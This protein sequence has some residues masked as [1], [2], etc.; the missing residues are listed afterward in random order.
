MHSCGTKFSTVVEVALRLYEFIF[1]RPR[2]IFS[3]N[4]LVRTYPCVV[5]DSTAVY[6]GTW[7]QYLPHMQARI[8]ENFL[9]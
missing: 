5:L 6:I 1:S 4:Y 3:S 8:S 7:Y 2:V 9:S